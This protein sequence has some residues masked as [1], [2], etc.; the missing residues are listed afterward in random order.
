MGNQSSTWTP[1]CIGDD[2]EYLDQRNIYIN[3]EHQFLWEYQRYK[4][5]LGWA[6]SENFEV[7]DPGRYATHDESSFGETLQV[8]I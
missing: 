2:N 1:T 7:D 4:P 5:G 8:V 3:P 6:A